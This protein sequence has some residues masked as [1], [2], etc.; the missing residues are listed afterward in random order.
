MHFPHG[1]SAIKQSNARG[2]GPVPR[3]ETGTANSVIMIGVQATMAIR[4]IV[5][6]SAPPGIPQLRS[7]VRAQWRSKGC[8][9]G[10]VKTSECP[11][12]GG[13]GIELCGL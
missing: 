9:L 4:Q 10:D 12:A 8:R 5:E 3:K 7:D 2:R 11:R 13:H 6:S 1:M